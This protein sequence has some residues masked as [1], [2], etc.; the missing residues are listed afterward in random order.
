[1]VTMEKDAEVFARRLAGEKFG[2][3]L[4]GDKLEMKNIDNLWN[5]N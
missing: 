1:M 5:K 3:V 4:E 2:I